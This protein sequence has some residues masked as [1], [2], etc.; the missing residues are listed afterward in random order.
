MEG[1]GPIY[2]L[3]INFLRKNG[4]MSATIVVKKVPPKLWCKRNIEPLPFRV[5]G[6]ITKCYLLFLQ[7][8]IS[9]KTQ[10]PP[11]QFGGDQLSMIFTS[12]LYIHSVSLIFC[13]FLL[14]HVG[15][16]LIYCLPATDSIHAP[17]Q[18]TVLPMF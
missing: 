2:N 4:N 14:Y 11:L 16:C 3:K 9:L 7:K 8:K 1:L 15:K 17:P 5:V 6:E 18:T 10:K 13:S 12:P